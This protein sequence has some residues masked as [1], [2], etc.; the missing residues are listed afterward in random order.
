MNHWLPWLS[1]ASPLP[2]LQVQWLFHALAWLALLTWCS[3][4]FVP[5]QDRRWRWLVCSVSWAALLFVWDAV[6]SGLGLAFQ[7]PSLVTL[8]VCVAAAWRDMRGT[9]TRLFYTTR[10]AKVS[11][12]L[13]ACI[14]GTGWL[15]VL[16]AFGQLPVAIYPLGFSQT[17]VW[18]AWLVCMLWLLS[19]YMLDAEDWHV[20]AAGCWLLASCVFVF[21]RAPSGNAWD[22]WLDPWLWLFANAQ[23]A[24]MA[25]RQRSRNN[26]S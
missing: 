21:T 12:V 15:L 23:L 24:R 5:V 13:W 3:V 1:D 22:A 10:P 26:H 6:L 9:P 11:A 17:I 18:L 7:T 4:A 8:C 19:A 2:D 14:A 20:Q 16:D 25:W